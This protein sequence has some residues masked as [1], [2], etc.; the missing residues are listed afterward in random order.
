MA[1]MFIVNS[2]SAVKDCLLDVKFIKF[3]KKCLL[4]AVYLITKI[5]LDFTQPHKLRRTK[6]ALKNHETFHL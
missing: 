1:H 4:F 2:K 3:M 5:C 6:A